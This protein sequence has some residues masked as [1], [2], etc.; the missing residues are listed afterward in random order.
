MQHK[1]GDTRDHAHQNGQSRGTRS[2]IHRKLGHAGDEGH[3]QEAAAHAKEGRDAGDNHAAK[4]RQQRIEGKFNATEGE[5]AAGDAEGN[6][7]HASGQFF[8]SGFALGR[9]F[10]SLSG[11]LGLGLGALPGRRGFPYQVQTKGQHE[12]AEV[13]LVG[14][15]VQ[16]ASSK[17]DRQVRAQNGT[18][19]KGNTQ[20]QHQTLHAVVAEGTDDG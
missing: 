12:H 18:Q 15:E 17:G 13:A 6:E 19:T 20:G 16:L 8:V 9:S 5:D 2:Q 10:K 14:R 1:G 4:E 11:F 3:Q 7:L